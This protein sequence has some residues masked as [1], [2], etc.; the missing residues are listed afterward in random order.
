ME[1]STIWILVCLFATRVRWVDAGFCDSS[2]CMN[3][4]KCIT[5]GCQCVT[6]YKGHLCQIVD[7]CELPDEV[8]AIVTKT[9]YMHVYVHDQGVTLG[10]PD[11]YEF[12]QCGLVY[13]T[14]CGMQTKQNAS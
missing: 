6:G 2:P 7:G 9:P 1:L 12:R 14:T 5:T 13:P 11:G 4:A 10:C 8:S 3:G